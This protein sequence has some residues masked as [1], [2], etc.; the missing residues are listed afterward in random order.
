MSHN[1][2]GP[3][4]TSG[5]LSGCRDGRCIGQ[6]NAWLATHPTPRKTPQPVITVTVEP[7]P[8]PVQ[9]MPLP[10]PMI[11]YVPPPPPPEPEMVLVPEFDERTPVGQV[12]VFDAIRAIR[13]TQHA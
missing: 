1:H 13:R 5:Y 3:P 11:P 2:G 10:V 7:E 8:A 4:S 6:Y 12:H 9:S